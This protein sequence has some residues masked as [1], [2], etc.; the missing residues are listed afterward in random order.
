METPESLL[1]CLRVRDTPRSWACAALPLP[2]GSLSLRRK[3]RKQYR[4]QTLASVNRCFVHRAP[5]IEELHQLLTCSVFVP[6]AI[7][8]DDLDEVFERFLALAFGIERHREIIA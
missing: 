2:Q 7:A 4:R 8:F 1:A 3:L 6:F 5:R